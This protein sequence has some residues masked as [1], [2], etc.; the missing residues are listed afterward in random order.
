MPRRG[1][2]AGVDAGGRARP[3]QARRRAGRRGRAV[4]ARGRGSRHMSTP[5]TGPSVA[6]AGRRCGF[7]AIIGAPNVGKSTLV[8]ALVG[9]KVTIVS[10]NLQTTPPTIRATPIKPAAQLIFLAT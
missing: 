1:A 10:P 2:G 5:D 3:L 4:V 9:A 8:N 6:P 7:V